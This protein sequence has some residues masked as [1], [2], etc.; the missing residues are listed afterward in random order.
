MQYAR[1]WM[2]VTVALAGTATVRADTALA[3]AIALFDAG[4]YAEAQKAFAAYATAHPKDAEGAYWTG[5]AFFALHD[6]PHAAEWLEKAA[7]LAPSRSD[8]FL[9]LGRADAQAALEA[10]V[11]RELGLAT[12]ARKAWEKAVAL[13]PANLDARAD[14]VEFHLVAPGFMGASVDEAR[15]Q[16]D[17]I[18]RRDPAR[19]AI[20]RASVAQHEK[21]LAGAESILQEALTHNPGDPHLRSS[22]GQL[23]QGEGKWEAAFAVYEAALAQDADSWPVLYQV[24]RAAALSGQH[25]DRGEAALRR[26]LGRT[27]AP[28]EP[29]LA[30]AH[31]RLG[32]ILERQGNRTGAR[33]EYLAALKLDPALKDA[34]S[35]LEKLG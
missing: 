30:Y 22:L 18:A 5:R 6:A 33:S 34:K 35:A 16:A 7:A 17:E 27:P 12:G 14:L 25:L 32:M 26:Y 3:P 21:D 13:D 4:R 11:F 20:A 28:D 29:P 31:Y 23:F 2:L 8:V 24:G 9:A 1:T 10:N 15:R 19:G